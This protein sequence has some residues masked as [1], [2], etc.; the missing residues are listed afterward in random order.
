MTA[1]RALIAFDDRVA[2]FRAHRANNGSRRTQTKAW[3]HS[4]PSA[5]QMAKAGFVFTP[6]AKA[7]DN[8]TCFL[9]DKSLDSWSRSDDPFAEHLSHSSD[10]P[11]AL[12]HSDWRADLNHNPDS[13]EMFNA[14]LDTFES[15][16]PHDG[17]RGWVP[18]SAAM[19]RAGF[20]YNPSRA[21]DDFAACMYCGIVLDGWEPKDDPMY[22]VLIRI[23]LVKI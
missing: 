22:V 11:W 20:Y 15:W 1:A 3:P 14:R 19:S 13:T 17:K 5:I 7:P 6:S 16:W 12:V 4:K 21:G 2:S 18:T 23:Q 10:C 8:V 9:C